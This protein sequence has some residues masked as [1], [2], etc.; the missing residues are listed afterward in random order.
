MARGFP[1][2]PTHVSRWVPSL[3]PKRDAFVYLSDFCGSAGVVGWAGCARA[4]PLERRIR[5]CEQATRICRLAP[6]LYHARKIVED[7]VA[8]PSMIDAYEGS[9]QF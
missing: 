7:A 8:A 2:A 6:R 1:L 3:E 9:A 4:T 5:I